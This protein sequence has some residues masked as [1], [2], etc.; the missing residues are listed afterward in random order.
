MR[1]YYL[2]MTLA[3]ACH[4]AHG[5]NQP[6]AE[7][8]YDGSGNRNFR[9]VEALPV[10]LIYFTAEKSKLTRIILKS[11]VAGMVKNG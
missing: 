4:W 9:K 11:S 7:Y 2:F 1:K 8:A 3:V 10:T 6:P 5:Q